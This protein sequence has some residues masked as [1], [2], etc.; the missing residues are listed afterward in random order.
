MLAVKKFKIP[1]LRI[2]EIVFI[3]ILLFL[4]ELSPALS[5]YNPDKFSNH[6]VESFGA[7]YLL[8]QRMPLKQLEKMWNKR[9]CGIY[10]LLEE[11]E[12]NLILPNKYGL[13]RYEY[14]KKKLTINNY[15]LTLNIIDD[16]SYWMGWGSGKNEEE[17]NNNW[18]KEIST[19]ISKSKS[20]LHIAEK[21]A[22]IQRYQDEYQVTFNIKWETIPDK[23]TLSRY[24]YLLFLVADEIYVEDF[25]DK[26]GKPIFENVAY[27]FIP[28]EGDD[29]KAFD[30]SGLPLVSLNRK[31]SPEN[32]MITLSTAT[33]KLPEMKRDTGWS[34]HLILED[35]ENLG[36]T[37]FSYRIRLL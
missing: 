22:L 16:Q 29:T 14:L 33:F 32:E 8:R 21:R 37:I 5:K 2:F 13:K 4:Q 12:E 27:D 31:I 9:V 11:R 20:K 26:L 7:P 3:V 23:E 19:L 18:L 1:I 35:P 10:Y 28:L 36:E 15:G 6:I 30:G 17:K 34:L 25:T 24:R